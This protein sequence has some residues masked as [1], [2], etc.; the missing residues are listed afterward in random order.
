[1]LLKISVGL[2]T[3][4]DRAAE[5]AINKYKD[6]RKSYEGH[7]GNSKNA[8]ACERKKLRGGNEY[9][10]AV[11]DVGEPFSQPK[12]SLHEACRLEVGTV[13]T[14]VILQQYPAESRSSC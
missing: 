6:R 9:T 13:T 11:S 10:R 12:Q 3:L 1:M 4:S 2:Y 5:L 8:D 7:N 14:D